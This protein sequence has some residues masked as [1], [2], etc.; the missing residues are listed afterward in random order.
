MG[1]TGLAGALD[2]AFST[3]YEDTNTF[4]DNALGHAEM[5]LKLLRQRQ[6]GE[7]STQ[8]ENL[9]ESMLA[10]AEVGP[11]VEWYGEV[12]GDAFDPFCFP[13]CQQISDTAP[14]APSS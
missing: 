10:L 12:V 5:A 3:P 1:S 9:L 11:V 2:K 8:E 13:L 4:Y 6:L 7:L 14:Q